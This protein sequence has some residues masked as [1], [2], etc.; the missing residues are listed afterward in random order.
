M[1]TDMPK[2]IE[3][4]RLALRPWE[5]ADAPILKRAIDGNLEHLRAWMPWA[6][7]EPS[8]VS[9]I[10]QRIGRFRVDFAEGTEWLYAIF[11][12]DESVFIGGCGLH[13]RIG[14]GG[15]E[16]GYWV[17]SAHT[18]RGFATE[19]AAAL[20][21]VALHAP[22]IERAE[23]RCDPRNLVSAKVPRRLRYRHVR[24]IKDDT[25]TPT[26]EPRDTMVW[27]LTQPEFAGPDVLSMVEV[28]EESALALNEYAR[29]SIA[30]EVSRVLD[31]RA[32][33]G[34]DAAWEISE[35]ALEQPY[36]KDYDNAPGEGPVR[37][38]DRFDMSKWGLF[39]ARVDGERVGG[40]AVALND[41]RLDMLD[42]RGDLALLW[43]I[44]VAANARGRGVGSALLRGVETWARARGARE[45]EV[46][47]QNINVPA[48]R[49]YQRHG[50][51]PGTM[52]R[53]AYPSLPDEI[54]LVWLKD[55][56]R[57]NPS[58]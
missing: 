1:P 16:I 47:T 45:L 54:Q 49:F 25:T 53:L 41:S 27:E 22:G 58:L 31:V 46:E 50:F 48:C 56:S 38:Q 30:F 3:T 55:L 43:D 10:E 40:A 12:R 20:T 19:A 18:R 28:V 57:H 34:A 8:P 21:R 15:L 9:V 39:A 35:R 26:G 23:I 4:Q 37:W 36:E 2:R 52:R 6:M 24:M 13:P 33:E 42:D 51:V 14:P 11:S 32:V 5:I 44:R 17:Q 29:V 7:E